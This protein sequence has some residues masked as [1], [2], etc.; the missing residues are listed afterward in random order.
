MEMFRGSITFTEYINL[1]RAFENIIQHNP[2]YLDWDKF[3]DLTCLV[4]KSLLL[5]QSENIY[6]ILLPIWNAC[7]R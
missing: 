5:N 1:A 3:E 2:K 6:D 4:I 7:V